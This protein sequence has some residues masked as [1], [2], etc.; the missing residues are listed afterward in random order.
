MTKEI[1]T[2]V[3]GLV[4]NDTFFENA[5]CCTREIPTP[6]CG[7]VRNDT[8]FENAVCCTREIPTPVCA[9]VRNDMFIDLRPA[10]RAESGLFPYCKFII[11]QSPMISL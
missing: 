1:P 10:V 8:F 11:Y 2:P 6:V 5:V 9:L 3:C 7:L 4:R